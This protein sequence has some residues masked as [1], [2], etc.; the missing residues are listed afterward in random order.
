MLVFGIGMASLLFGEELQLLLSHSSFALCSLCYILDKRAIL[1]NERAIEHMRKFIVKDQHSSLPPE[2][3]YP[4]PVSYIHSERLPS[5]PVSFFSSQ[6]VTDRALEAC[7]SQRPGLHNISNELTRSLCMQGMRFAR[8][9]NAFQI[10]I[11]FI[12]E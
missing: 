3:S 9:T 12:S 10:Q 6:D 5:Y 4:F 8:A 2:S 1:A 11:D 7:L